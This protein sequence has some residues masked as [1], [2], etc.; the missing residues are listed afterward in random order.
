M[1]KQMSVGDWIITYLLLSIPVINIIC[2]FI[3]AFGGTKKPSRKTWAQ[4]TLLLPLIILFFL[5]VFGWIT[6]SALI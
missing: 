3:W 5:V 4:A 6:G 1:E 2:I